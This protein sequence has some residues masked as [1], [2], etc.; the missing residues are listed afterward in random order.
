MIY[1]T[2]QINSSNP[3]SIVGQ[4]QVSRLGKSDVH[5]DQFQRDWNECLAIRK[6]S[7]MSTGGIEDI[8]WMIHALSKYGWVFKAIPCSIFVSV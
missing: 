2:V 5:T 3:N 8:A 1:A 7:G 4:Y 6:E